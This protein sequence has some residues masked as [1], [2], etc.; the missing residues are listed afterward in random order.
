MRKGEILLIVIGIIVIVSK[1]SFLIH[2]QFKSNTNR[3]NVVQKSNLN[4]SN[5]NSLAVVIQVMQAKN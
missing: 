5:T 1:S 2:I 3:G 4:L